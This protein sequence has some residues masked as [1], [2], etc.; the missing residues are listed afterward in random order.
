MKLRKKQRV[1]FSGCRELQESVNRTSSLELLLIYWRIKRQRIPAFCHSVSGRVTVGVPEQF[2]RF[3]IER[4]KAW[5]P[6]ENEAQKDKDQKKPIDEFK[7]LLGWLP[8]GKRIVFILDGLD[9]LA[10]HDSTFAQRFPSPCHL[11]V[12]FGYAQGDR[13]VDYRE[14]FTPERCQH[15]FPE[16]LSPMST[17][18]IPM[19]LIE[20]I[21]TLRRKLVGE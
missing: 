3:A 17:G 20:K 15:V 21:G 12:F 18:G 7:D 5:K 14:A 2:L 19:M 11:K 4:L 8:K 6:L 1:V 13:N 10:E 9:E 16:G